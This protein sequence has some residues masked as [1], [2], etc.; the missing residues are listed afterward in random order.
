MKPRHAR[1]HR[2]PRALDGVRVLD[3]T[4]VIAGPVCTRTLAAH[5]ADVLRVDTPA[6]PEIEAQAIDALVGKRS[7]FIDLRSPIGDAEL[8]HL[9]DDADVLVTGYRPGSL[10]QFGLAPAALAAR[11]PGLVVLNLS[12]WGHEGP[13]AGRRG[14]DSLVQAA[15]GIAVAESRTE[16]VGDGDAGGAAGAGAR[17]RD[18]VPR[19]RG[20]HRR[21]GAPAARR[22]HVARAVLARA[23]RGMAPPPT[24]HRTVGHRGVRPVR[25]T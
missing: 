9:L 12:A 14:F 23:D 2:L 10:D 3:L 19:G 15:S 24:P 1:G 20:D 25:A 17:P 11:H 8:E 7:A 22:R 6:L 21:S 18:R 4:R 5:G 16:V 13:W